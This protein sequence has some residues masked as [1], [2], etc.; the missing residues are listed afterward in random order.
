MGY[1]ILVVDDE[2]PIRELL[3][4]FLEGQGHTVVLA[5]NGEEALLLA[6]KESPHLIVLDVRMPGLDGIETCAALRANEKTRAIPIILATA[7]R[8]VLAEALEAGVDDFVTK[9]FHLAE[10]LLRVQALLRVRHL[11]DELERAAAYICELRRNLP[12]E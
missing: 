5:S 2:E 8:D 1:K 9:P 4:G 12:G 11:E 10:L 6:E 3:E 7:F